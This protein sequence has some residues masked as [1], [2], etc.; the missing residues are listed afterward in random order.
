MEN[1]K[2][3]L[4]VSNGF[5]PEISPRSFRATELAAEFARQG[6][7]VTIYTKYRDF[8]YTEF[9]NNN[10][11]SLRMWG[12]ARFS[13]IPKFKGKITGLISRAI[14]RLLLMLFEYP[15]IEEMFKVKR[16][17]KSESNYDLLISFAFPYPIHWGVAWSRTNKHPIARIWVADCGDPFMG[18]AVDSF[19]KL[20]YFKY[21]EKWWSRKANYISIPV[22]SARSARDPD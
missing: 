21:V 2:R 20:F 6:H 7:E 16:A 5:Y 8:D 12:K 22:E 17:L 13:D 3:I 15:Y 1:K 10:K 4:L 9:L 14:R 11:L 18:T 19:K